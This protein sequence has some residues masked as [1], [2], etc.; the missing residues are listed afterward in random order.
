MEHFETK[1][2]FWE[3]NGTFWEILRKFHFFWHPSLYFSICPFLCHIE[4]L[5]KKWNILRTF[6]K[7]WNILRNFEKNPGATRT[8]GRALC[9]KP[10][11]SSP[12]LFARLSKCQKLL[13][14][15]W[16]NVDGILFTHTSVTGQQKKQKMNS[17]TETK[18]KV[19]VSIPRV[20]GD[21]AN[22]T[23]KMMKTG[24]AFA[25]RTIKPLQV[26]ALESKPSTQFGPHGNC[27]LHRQ[28]KNWQYTFTAIRQ[29]KSSIAYANCLENVMSLHAVN[30][31]FLSL[32]LFTLAKNLL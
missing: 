10:Y 29:E 15:N 26:S 6:E 24:F 25:W 8:S 16:D 14:K 31:F 2:T 12:P 23:Q 5:R 28:L 7:K 27:Q 11:R 17:L 1:I 3:K 22:G 4:V 9:E 20:I 30:I 18:C 13:R 21:A 19:I 32:V